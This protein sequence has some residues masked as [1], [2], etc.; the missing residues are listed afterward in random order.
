MKTILIILFSITTSIF[1]Q[2][3]CCE[4]FPSD[5]CDNKPNPCCDYLPPSITCNILNN[6]PKAGFNFEFIFSQ[7]T[8]DGLDYAIN[9][10][11]AKN[12]DGTICKPDF[13]W[14]LGARAGIEYILNHDQWILN[15]NTVI[16]SS[17]GK[18]RQQR[19]IVNQTTF[20]EAFD[21]TGLIPSWNHPDS[22]GGHLQNIRYANS[23]VKWDQDFYA[24][25]LMLEKGFC[26]S[27]KIK[28]K[29]SIGLGNL[30]IF[31]DYKVHYDNGKIFPIAVDTT[32]SP[33]SSLSKNKQDTFGV[34]PR[35]G[36]DTRWY[37]F[38]N[39]NF[40]AKAYG[41]LL[42][43]YIYSSRHDINNFIIDS[44][45]S[46][47]NLKMQHDFSSIK[48]NME[49]AL[50][51]SYEH[52]IT[53]KCKSPTFIRF[54]FGYGNQYFWKKNK[55]IQFADDVNDGLFYPVEGDLYM[56]EFN[57]GVNCLF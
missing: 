17:K 15:L 5:Q 21:N 53:Y 47:D 8:Q 25:N 57:F 54:S 52:C 42:Y 18:D 51:I 44:V 49:L 24:I 55:Y 34:G 26:I 46:T 10:S 43:T 29:P 9:N 1:A 2:S 30:L 33:I 19:D 4:K 3:S 20:G 35:A 45:D 22:Y 48:P 11:S 31:D 38:K 41:S 14:Y 13:D 23:N 40:F 7:P 16:L 32:V 6:H 28:I 56:Q 37:I 39:T 27:N 36:I 12:I 50:G